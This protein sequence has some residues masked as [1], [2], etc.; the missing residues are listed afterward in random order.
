MLDTNLL[1]SQIVKHLT[2]NKQYANNMPKV[3][4]IEIGAKALN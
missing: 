3:A 4:Y 2:I 1:I